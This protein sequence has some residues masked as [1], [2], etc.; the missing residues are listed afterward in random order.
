LRIFLGNAWH[1]RGNRSQAAQR[2]ELC[3]AT[4]GAMELMLGVALAIVIAD[5]LRVVWRG[6]VARR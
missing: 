5:A 1:E 2:G 6:P 3:A 4:G